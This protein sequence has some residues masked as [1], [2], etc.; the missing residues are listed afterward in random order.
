MQTLD[1]CLMKNYFLNLRVVFDCFDSTE[2]TLV[3]IKIYQ[4]FMLI[5]DKML[6]HLI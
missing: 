3:Y 6:N 4:K 1:Q 2:I 5:K